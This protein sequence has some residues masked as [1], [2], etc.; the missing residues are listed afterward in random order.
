MT[1]TLTIL[2][3]IAAIAALAVSAETA[4][5]ATSA[6]PPTRTL[7]YTLNNTMVSGYSLSARPTNGIIMKDGGICDPIRHMGC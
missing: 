7:T 1:R 6:T 3:A 4:S 5:A 2:A